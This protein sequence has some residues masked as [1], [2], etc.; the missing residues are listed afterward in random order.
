MDDGR[1]GSISA[2]IGRPWK[3]G[4]FITAAARAEHPYSR[5]AQI[6][7]DIRRAAFLN[8]TE[9]IAKTNEAQQWALAKWARRAEKLSHNEAELH[10][11][12]HPEVAPCLAGK[13]SLLLE[14]M[15]AAAGLQSPAIAGA[16]LRDGCPVFGVFQPRGSS[17]RR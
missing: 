2:Q 8:L 12:A 16:L 3:P 17:S 10:A 1:G 14:E 9:G 7:D 6:A 15:A 13:R 11:R 4:E 5:P